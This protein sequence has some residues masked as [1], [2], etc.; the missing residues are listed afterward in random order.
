MKLK[1]IT[2]RIQHETEVLKG[3]ETRDL[4]Y[5]SQRT[6]SD[7][8]TAGVAFVRATQKLWNVERWSD[9]SSFTADFRLY[10]PTGQ[11]K[12]GG[13]PQLNDYIE[14]ILPGPAPT[15]WVRVTHKAADDK[16]AEFTV[17]PSRNPQDRETT[18]IA[19]FFDQNA[20]STFR[21]ELLGKTLTA[22][23]IGEHEGINNQEPQAGDRAV[24]NTVVAEAGWLFYQKIQW[25]LLTDYLVHL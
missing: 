18:G 1:A 23:E 8:A 14:V 11:P 16:R 6:F 10:D 17:Q 4:V 9:L 25:K 2:D 20:R 22:S 5:A 13:E 21:V 24:V 12:P 15:N 19:H 7:E 3:N